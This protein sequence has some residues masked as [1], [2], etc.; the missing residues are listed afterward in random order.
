MQIAISSPRAAVLTPLSK[1]TTNHSRSSTRLQSA[2]S[3][4]DSKSDKN[5]GTGL[6]MY[7]ATISKEVMF[8]PKVNKL[9]FINI[10]SRELVDTHLVSVCS[11][12]K[13]LRNKHEE[14]NNNARAWYI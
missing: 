13:I 6:L 1:S 2:T 3:R 7:K 5:A 14:K 9:F 11:N 8:K 4:L 12:F 10:T